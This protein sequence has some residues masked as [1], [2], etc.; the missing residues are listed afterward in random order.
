[1]SLPRL[2]ANLGMLFTELPLPEAIRAAHR[3]GFDAVECHWPY[4][5]AAGALRRALRETGL[6]MLS[7][8]TAPG[9][10]EAGEFGLAALPGREAEARAATARAVGHAVRIGARAVHVMAGITGGGAAAEATFRANLLHACTLAAPH[11][12]GVLIE[13]INRRDVPGY[14]LSRAAHAARIIG[15]LAQPGLRLIFDCYHMAITE[16][17]LLPLF[18]HLLPVI[19][20]VQIAA[21]AD[22]GEPDAGVPD[23]TRLLPAMRAAGYEGYFGAEYRPRQGDTVSG[24]GWMRAL[25]KQEPRP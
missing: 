13:P 14:H 21:L 1:M 16:G 7:L 9:D 12:L 20:H 6:P 3:A 19:G 25:G 17:E 18:H 15:E 22:R 2:S 5:T 8:N 11:G 24:L 4:A 10:R 23:Y